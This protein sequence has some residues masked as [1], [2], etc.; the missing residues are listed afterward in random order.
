MEKPCKLRTITSLSGRF[1]GKTH[2]PFLCTG[3]YGYLNGTLNSTTMKIKEHNK[4]HIK[5]DS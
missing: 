5:G 4:F 1:L 3:N 2:A